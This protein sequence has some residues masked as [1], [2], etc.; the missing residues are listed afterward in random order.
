[1]SKVAVI[2]GGPA[3]MMAAI[4]A[5]ENGHKVTIFDK[6]EKLGK[7]L[8]ITGKGRCNVTNSCNAD[9]FFNG[10]IRNPK[11]LYSAL[12]AYDNFAV[13]DFF[14]GENVPLKIERGGR[15]F[16]ESDHSSDII[17]ALENKLKERKVKIALKTDV[18][19]LTIEDG[20][21]RGFATDRKK[22][23]FDS[24]ILAMGGES[25]PSTGSTGD[26]IGMA[27]DLGLEVSKCVPALVPLDV[28]E[29]KNIYFEDL[30]GLSL[31][32]VSL[33]VFWEGKELDSFF[34]EMIFTHFG[35][36]GPIVLECS[37]RYAEE[38]RLG[39]VKCEID[40][41]PALSEVKLDKRM[42]RDFDEYKN[43]DIHNALKDLLPSGLI[44]Y[45]L[46][47]SKIS[48]K[49]KIN[50]ITK[51]ERM[52][53]SYTIKHLPFHITKTRGFDEAIITCGGVSVRE[54]N[55]GTMESKKIKNLYLAG[56]M[57]DVH[58]ITGGYNLQIAWST[59]YLAGRSVQ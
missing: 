14:E 49:A 38:I 7:K 21:V 45:V 10:I 30:N 11:F 51:Q 52:R 2:G 48:P 55:P 47:E 37:A 54:I 20:S 25:Y 15:V 58:G 31:K 44:G 17:R 32:N 57:I 27:D 53:L 3:G 40:L 35:I 59:G 8:F 24:V 50:S 13:M 34:G 41:K 9:S 12:S 4:A 36:S 23:R 29:V 16:P 56:E 22:Y 19:S 6:N 28:R 18:K 1:M 46:Y 39:H 5:S 43:K 42:L 26:W 33:S